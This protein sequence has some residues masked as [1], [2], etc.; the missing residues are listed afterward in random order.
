MVRSILTQ[1]TVLLSCATHVYFQKQ[2]FCRWNRFWMPHFRNKYRIMPSLSIRRIHGSLF[3]Q[4]IATF[5]LN[6][7]ITSLNR[8]ASQIFE[9]ILHP[10]YWRRWWMI[11]GIVGRYTA[12]LHT[13]FSAMILMSFWLRVFSFSPGIYTSANWCCQASIKW[14]ICV[15]PL[16]SRRLWRILGCPLHTRI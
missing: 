14:R 6:F 3:C 13:T 8:R 15:S 11:L 7:T 1:T 10:W 9:N 2:K 12:Q 4:L 5:I 16:C